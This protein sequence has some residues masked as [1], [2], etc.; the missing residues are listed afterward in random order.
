MHFDLLS[1]QACPP[2]PGLFLWLRYCKI[3]W[4][5]GY[6]WICFMAKHIYLWFSTYRLSLLNFH[7]FFC[8]ALTPKRVTC[9]IIS[10]HV[11]GCVGVWFV[12]VCMCAFGQSWVHWVVFVFHLHMDDLKML[13]LPFFWED[14][15]IY[16]HPSWETS[17]LSRLQTTEDVSARSLACMRNPSSNKNLR[18]I[19]AQMST[20]CLS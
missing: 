4:T 1:C 5:S 15:R 14:F 12:D 10:L 16:S 3:F 2:Q 7:V 19:L 11:C 18:L 8:R 20:C 9:A 6:E 17:D 13:E